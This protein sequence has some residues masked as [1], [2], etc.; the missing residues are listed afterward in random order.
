MTQDDIWCEF[1]EDR[2]KA[3]TLVDREDGRQ[4]DVCKHC[5]SLSAGFDTVK[6]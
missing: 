2:I 4:Y 3:V 1:C 6:E 5:A